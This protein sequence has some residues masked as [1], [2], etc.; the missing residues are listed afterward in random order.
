MANELILIVE[1]NPKNLKLVRDSLQVK[2]YQTIDT[3]TGEEG[4]RLARE[5]RPALILMDIQLPG[6]NGVE[7]LRQLRAD[8]MTNAIPVIA[9]TASVMTDD[10][11]RIMAAGFDGFHGKPI[12][13][14]NDATIF[15]IDGDRLRVA[16]HNGPIASHPIGQGPSLAWGTPSGRAVLDR[17]PIHVADLQAEIDEYPEGSE[18][19]RRLGFRTVLAAPLMQEGVAIGVINLRRTEARLFTE[20][21]VALLQTFA[22]QAVIAIENVRLFNETKEALE[23]QT[24]TSD[25]LR[26]I[27]SS[28][29]DVQPV[30]DA[31][32]ASATRLCEADF[33]GLYQFDGTWAAHLH[34]FR[35]PAAS[36]YR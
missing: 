34:E 5:R 15:Q 12:C 8:P 33:S 10:R 13:D 29:T 19:S 31:I 18:H 1:D 25:I 23:Q 27:S 14:A 21:Q 2:G 26:V 35:P 24:A 4:M 3:E 36:R 17:R 6:I 30:F 7:A 9:V 16:V 11:T 28:P 22:D 20:R 32:A